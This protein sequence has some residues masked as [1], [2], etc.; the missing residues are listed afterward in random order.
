MA[1]FKEG[2]DKWKSRKWYQ[3]A[4]DIFFWLLLIS[5]IIPGPRKF[6]ATTVNK[7]ALHLKHPSVSKDQNAYQMSDEDYNWD[8]RTMDDV[9]VDGNSLQGEVIFLNFWG[10]YCPPCIAEMP[11]IQKLYND[12]GDKVKFILI[13]AESPEKIQNFLQSREYDLPSYTG[14]RSMPEALSVRS[15]PTTFLISRD[16]KIVSKKVGAAAWNSKATRKAL[17]QLIAK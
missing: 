13:S 7:L 12:Y 4:G 6:V 3:K 8:I 14:G 10:T 9:Q 11:E 2:I 15:I 5:M 16:G 17:D 1:S